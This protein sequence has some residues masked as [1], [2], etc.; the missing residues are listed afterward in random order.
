MTSDSIQDWIESLI[1]CHATTASPSPMI[2]TRQ[3]RSPDS[4]TLVV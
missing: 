1:K 3:R 2:P 4:V